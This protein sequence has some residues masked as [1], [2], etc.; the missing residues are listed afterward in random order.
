MTK[1]I[2]E[3]ASARNK[4]KQ[5]EHTALISELNKTTKTVWKMNAYREAE[6]Q[7]LQ[8]SL[9]TLFRIAKIPED[10]T[11][12]MTDLTKKV[13]EKNEKI[14]GILTMKIDSNMKTDFDHTETS[15]EMTDQLSKITENNQMLL[16]G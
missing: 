15:A 12:Q 6:L 11:R 3:T 13:R 1:E 16:D 14:T 9:Q 5:E 10:I 7:N 2:I 8:K 4:L